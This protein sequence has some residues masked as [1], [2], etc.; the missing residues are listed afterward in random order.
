MLARKNI[1]GNKSNERPNFLPRP[2]RRFQSM[3]IGVIRIKA[4]VNTL[5]A[6]VT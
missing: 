4:S 5:A 3:G 6:E 2:T 1:P